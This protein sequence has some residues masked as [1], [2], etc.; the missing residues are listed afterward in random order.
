MYLNKPSFAQAYAETL[1]N[2]R[3]KI[4]GEPDGFI[5]GSDTEELVEYYFVPK[6]LTP[7]KID[8][9][10]QEMAEPINEMKTV[11]ANRR[12]DSY[13]NEAICLMNMNQSALQ[14]RLFRTLKLLR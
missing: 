6:A 9:E 12:E 1:E 3:L 10:R 13:R 8:P 14:Y 7:I 2:I 11:P 5:I 4:L